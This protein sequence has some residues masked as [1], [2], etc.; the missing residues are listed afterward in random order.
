[1]WRAGIAHNSTRALCRAVLV[2]RCSDPDNIWTARIED[3]N[4]QFFDAVGRKACCGSRI[5]AHGIKLLQRRSQRRLVAARDSFWKTHEHEPGKYER[6]VT[7]TGP[8]LQGVCLQG[9]SKT[10]N[11]AFELLQDR[12]FWSSRVDAGAKHVEFT[13]N[14]RGY[15]TH[16]HLLTYGSYIERDTN[17]EAK[18]KQWRSERA[19]QQKARG[20]R[21]LTALSPLGNLQDEWSKCL[22]QAVGEFGRVIEWNAPANHEGWYCRFPLEAGEVI[23]VQPTRAAKANVDVRLV[24]EKGRPSVGEIGL[25]SAIKELTKYITKAGSWSDVSDEQLVE[26]AE[27]QRWPRCF[28]LF[29]AWRR[30]RKN[31]ESALVDARVVLSIRH[32]ETW[33]EFCRRVARDDGHPDSYVIAWEALNVPGGLF[34]GDAV[35]DLYAASGG[36]TAS[37]D[38]DFVFRSA[39]E[40]SESP[41]SSKMPIRARAPSLMELGGRV[42]FGEWLKFV[43]I[44]LAGGRKARA[45]LLARKYPNVRFYCLDGSEFGGAIVGVA[46]LGDGARNASVTVRGVNCDSALAA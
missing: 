46:R 4:G 34:H 38:T 11:R 42:P 19:A 2:G 29:G 40:P 13:V 28:E 26:I 45:R 41:P 33:E 7:L 20:L 35:G 39:S 9:S 24:R 8:T 5:C 17:E 6:F 1:M 44:R 10:Y 15:H 21:L 16:A 36:D 32:S 27:V 23:E 22:T 3:A 37:L 18:T 30:A 12:A 25:H 43:S 14:V 31:N